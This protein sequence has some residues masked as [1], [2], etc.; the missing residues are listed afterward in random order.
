MFNYIFGCPENKKWALSLYNAMNNTS[1]SDD[2]GIEINTINDALHIEMYNDAS[3]I[4]S[5]TTDI[6]EGKKSIK[7]DMPLRQ[8]KYLGKIREEYLKKRAS[9]E[10]VAEL[11]TISATQLVVFHNNI[12]EKK[13]EVTFRLSNAF[14]GASTNT[15]MEIDVRMVNVSGGQNEKLMKLCK[16][17]QEYAW[18]ISRIRENCKKF[19]IEAATNM[20]IEFM[21]KDFEIKSFLSD[22]KLEIT[23]LLSVKYSG[24][25]PTEIFKAESLREGRERGFREGLEQGIAEGIEQGIETINR[26]NAR[27]IRAGRF[28]DLKRAARNIEYQRALIV[29]L[30]E[31]KNR[32]KKAATSKAR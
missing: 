14:P 19:K 8:L 23:E 20:A 32:K 22:H 3:Y 17:L 6:F 10:N 31:K 29:E 26:L 18:L 13:E 9:K 7:P 30:L 21:P 16:P 25:K 2:V 1:Y 15:P 27:L 11:S 28:D 4:I 24:E 5:D 12:S